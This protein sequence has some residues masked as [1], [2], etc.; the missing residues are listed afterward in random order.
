MTETTWHYV[1]FLELKDKA[2]ADVHVIREPT[3]FQ[4]PRE[5]RRYHLRMYC[6]K[7][8]AYEEAVL[9][10]QENDDPALPVVNRRGAPLLP[11]LAS[12]DEPTIE[13]RK[14]FYR[15]KYDDPAVSTVD[16]PEATL[17][18][19][20]T[21]EGWIKVQSRAA[22]R[23]QKRREQEETA[24][25]ARDD[26]PV[27]V[28]GS[29]GE[30]VKPSLVYRNMPTFELGPHG[31]LQSKQKPKKATFDEGPRQY[32]KP[33]FIDGVPGHVIEVLDDG[34]H[35]S[36][37]TARGEKCG[38]LR[39]AGDKYKP[40]RYADK[41]GWY[42][43]DMPD[44]E[45][46]EDTTD[47]AE[48]EWVDDD[49][50]DFRDE[51][52]AAASI[53]AE[54]NFGPGN[55]GKSNKTSSGAA[56]GFLLGGGKVDEKSG[57][58][59]DKSRVR[60]PSTGTFPGWAALNRRDSEQQQKEESLIRGEEEPGESQEDPASTA[61]LR[62]IFPPF[63]LKKP[64]GGGECSPDDIEKKAEETEEFDVFKDAHESFTSPPPVRRSP[65]RQKIFAQ[66]DSAG[67]EEC[68]LQEN[69]VHEKL[70]DAD[71][72]DIF[73]DAQESLPSSTLP[74]KFPQGQESFTCFDPF[75]GDDCLSDSDEGADGGV[76][77]QNEDTSQQDA[78]ERGQESLA[79][80]HSGRS[81]Q[82]QHRV[83][84]PFDP[85]GSDEEPEEPDEAVRCD[86]PETGLT[87]HRGSSQQQAS[88]RYDLFD[89]DDDP[90]ETEQCDISESAQEGFSSPARPRHS[91]ISGDDW[92]M[93]VSER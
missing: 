42:W 32:F 86:S 35:P 48:D 80:A 91:S 73:E 36:M 87:R 62:R 31:A 76:D 19:S 75:G 9:Y 13:P 24:R 74:L 84:A 55:K 71:E 93:P 49:L 92:M 72:H 22:L 88:A 39:R 66:S 12:R 50:V 38:F 18:P 53:Y 4:T 43:E 56:F 7:R 21:A 60:S 77:E 52:D 40:G 8:R 3:K 26:P 25:R 15:W 82:Q 14:A 63:A 20:L 37:E 47:S 33:T 27:L 30:V 67:G 11:S 5:E 6:Q 64:I 51:M 28:V 89:V 29:H 54:F 85:F 81:P 68:P 34:P 78:V 16:T 69:D 10:H 45:D 79:S 1:A 41:D 17:E 57:P 90:E 58:P 44:F 61:R 65:Q 23:D 59:G 46:A 70:Q 83:L 2:R